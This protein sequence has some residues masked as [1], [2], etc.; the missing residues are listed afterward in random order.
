MACSLTPAW[1]GVR[2]RPASAAARL[3]IF[4]RHLRAVR[5]AAAARRA[6]VLESAAWRR[7][8]HEPTAKGPR[9]VW[10]GRT[11]GRA[12]RRASPHARSSPAWRRRVPPFHR[13]RPQRRRGPPPLR[14][15]PPPLLPPPLRAGRHGSATWHCRRCAARRGRP[16]VSTDGT[17]PLGDANDK[18]ESLDARRT[19]AQLE[20][21]AL[22]RPQC[23]DHALELRRR[24]HL[25]L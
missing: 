20:L 12:R 6:A 7:Q 18:T 10:R 22:V 4:A 17:G 15:L 23:L 9:A 11:R 25:R 13:R 21:D 3:R 19:V 14:G 5:S 16:G 1:I 8:T 24:V 2:G